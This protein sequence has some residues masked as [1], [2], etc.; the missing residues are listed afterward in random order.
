MA[1]GLHPDCQRRLREV[2]AKKLPEIRVDYGMFLDSQT[3]WR[4]FLAEPVMPNSGPARTKLEKYIGE[5][6][7]AE[8]FVEKL[9]LDLY[10]N[11]F[12]KDV[13]SQSI[14]ELAGYEDAAAVA[15]YLV[16]EFES[17]P[18]TYSLTVKLEN[19]FS[20]LMATTINSFSLSES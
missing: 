9:S 20:G 5:F 6:A 11:H 3:T 13:T 1:L 8:F 2:I 14:L 15:K 16:D 18:W 12:E 7:A 4:L 19:D 10:Q 17:L